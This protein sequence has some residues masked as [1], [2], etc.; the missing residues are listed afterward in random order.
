MDLDKPEYVFE[1]HNHKTNVYC[2][3]VV[4]NT[5]LGP[6]LGGIRLRSYESDD[7]AKEDCVRLAHGMT[8]KSALAELP[9]GG[10]KTVINVPREVLQKTNRRE[11]LLE[12]ADWL[13]K[14][15]S[16]L[17]THNKSY[18]GGEDVGISA[19]DITFIAQ[20]TKYVLGLPCG[21]HITLGTTRV[22]GGDPSPIT[23]VGVEAGIE[24]AVEW[25][26]KGKTLA[27]IEIAVQGVGKVG[28]ALVKRLLE[29]D[30]AP[31]KIIFTDTSIIALE[32]LFSAVAREH[33]MP[34]DR[35]GRL[36]CISPEHRD[37]IYRQKCDIFAPCALGA[38]LNENTIP[39]LKCGIVAGSANN[40]LATEEDD[41][42]LHNRA[43]LYIPDYIINAGGLLNIAEELKDNLR[44]YNREAAQSAARGIKKRVRTVL[45]KS[46]GNIEPTG[47]TA[48][49]M[50]R[51][52]LENAKRSC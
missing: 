6:A 41:R 37:Q 26:Y 1:Q 44:G 17:R 3:T 5:I 2:V 27:D 12:I 52:I 25:F 9:H 35:F 32:N 13:E 49:K 23:A 28:T 33:H 47:A 18:W 8:N 7:E 10:G 20:H 19:E 40:Q 21:K 31:R 36:H 15:N 16:E 45:E 42:R 50:A 14:V 38:I 43:I 24:A 4:D 48:D 30:D 22:G 11:L 29:R 34:A 51:K 39:Q 46:Y